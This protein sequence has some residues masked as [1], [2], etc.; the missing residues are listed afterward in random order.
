MSDHDRSE[1]SGTFRNPAGTLPASS[2]PPPPEGCGTE[3]SWGRYGF[4]AQNAQRNGRATPT[5]KPWNDFDVDRDCDF[6]HAC[7][8]VAEILADDDWHTK[9]SVIESVSAANLDL[10]SKTISGLITQLK[11]HGDIREH[12]KRIRLT[13]RWQNGPQ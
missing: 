5:L 12:G 7:R 3:H 13:T 2:V 4:P 1:C 8:M 10:R 9:S 6:A 11:A